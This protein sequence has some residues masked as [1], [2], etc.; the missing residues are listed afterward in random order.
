[1]IEIHPINI[2]EYVLRFDS[3]LPGLAGHFVRQ[4]GL[5]D[6]GFLLGAKHNGVPCGVAAGYDSGQTSELVYIAVRDEYRQKGVRRS[7]IEHCLELARQ[8]GKKSLKLRGTEP[9][10]ST[11]YFGEYLQKKG[12]IKYPSTVTTIAPP[13]DANKANWAA[14]I[15]R[16]NVPLNNLTDK[17]FCTVDFSQATP[18]LLQELYARIGTDFPAW[19][20]PR[21]STNQMMPLHSFITTY[22]GSPVTYCVAATIP[23]SEHTAI[24]EYMAVS[25]GFINKGVFLPSL[26]SCVESL[27]TAG[28]KVAWTVHIGN[29]SMTK[30]MH[31]KLRFSDVTVKY[32]DEYWYTL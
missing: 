1:M 17:G 22:R 6:N 13:S 8:A 12:F 2:I 16:I 25:S 3:G 31:N 20:D 18:E 26:V 10:T 5:K 7:L 29:K 11:D 21:K 4:C 15:S 27:I 30:L 9:Q 28:K 19:L 32:Q 23:G 14:F 24:V